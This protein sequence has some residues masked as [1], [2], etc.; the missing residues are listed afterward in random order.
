[1]RRDLLDIEKEFE[2]MKRQINNLF[3]GFGDYFDDVP[4]LGLPTSKGDLMTNSYKTPKTDIYE[5]DKE[6]VAKIEIPGVNKEEIKLKF[7]NGVLN[8]QA[9]HK[10]EKE[11]KDEKKGYHRF[12][13]SY[14]SF[15][16]SFALPAEID[17]NQAKADYKNGIL[18]VHMPKKKGTE[19]KEIKYIDI[20]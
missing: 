17:V 16:R 8:L 6:V 15:M 3:E 2:R 9:E 18:E 14:A 20:K 19:K 4:L 13:R 10:A 5:T 1:M 12:E 11:D 7:E